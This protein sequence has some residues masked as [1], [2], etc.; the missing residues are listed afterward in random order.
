MIT[1]EEFKSALP[2][3]FR[4]GVDKAVIANVNKALDDPHTREMMQENILGFSSV[5]LEGKFTITK[6]V[7][8]VRFASYRMMGNNNKISYAK[9]FPDRYQ[10][11]IN[12]GV[13][14]KDIASYISAYSK[15]KLVTLILTQALTPLHIINMN[16]EQEAIN[17]LAELM[18]NAM[19]EH[20]R[21]QSAK[22]L[23]DALKRPE[24]IK[25]ELDVNK[26][27]RASCRERV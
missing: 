6:Y 2:A 17:V 12:E 20:V 8:A 1:P 23:L 7:S 4:N 26:I 10:R 15:S 5:L 27:G 19:S 11:F 16:K 3:K 14:T 25:L 18:T 21:R 22:D 24:T 9:T 13:I